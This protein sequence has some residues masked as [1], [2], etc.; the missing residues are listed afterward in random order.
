MPDDKITVFLADDNLIV[1]EG[2]RALLN[3]QPDIEVVG[4]AADY[5]EIITF[6]DGLKAAELGEQGERS[7]PPAVL[8][9]DIRMPPNFTSEGI[10]AAKEVRRRYSGTGTVVLSQYDDPEYAAALLAEGSEGYAYL[11]KDRVGEGNQLANAVRAVATG[12]SM[13]DP[14]IVEAMVSPVATDALTPVEEELLRMVAEGKPIK[15]IAAAR[16]TTPAAAAG[17]VEQVFLKIAKD[18]SAGT[19]GALKRLQMLHAAI[20]DRE[21]VGERLEKL[22]PGGIADKMRAEG[23]EPGHTE[24]LTVTVLMSDVRGYSGIAER[25]DPTLLAGQLNNH[26]ALLN[27]AILSHGG[28]V[29][30]FTGDGVMAV[31]GAPFPQ[32]DHADRAL[33]AALQMH[34]RQDVLNDEWIEQSLT[35][36]RLG[37]GLCTGEVAAALLGSAERLEYTLV[38]D[39]VNLSARLQD[40]ARP[41][42][43][44]VLSEATYLALSEQPE[45]EKL[46]P[47][48]VKGRET[49]VNAYKIEAVALAA[50]RGQE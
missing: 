19:A 31:F 43:Q 9:T 37:V 29:M 6:Y 11:L 7:A 18:A 28:T 5:D 20:I 16:G 42:G 3:L 26:R 40:L 44:V 10:D 41:G 27:D 33:E 45:A 30:Q 13:L 21:E 1:R 48:M 2:V 35:P 4:V 34:V 12:K 50:T 22:L 36:F 38:G 46:D 25:T 47:T 14:K 23:M 17:D 49:P 15:A 32:E 24:R 39:T 8:V